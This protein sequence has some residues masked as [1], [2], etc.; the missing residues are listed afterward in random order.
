MGSIKQHGSEETGTSNPQVLNLPASILAT[1]FVCVLLI[2]D[3][4]LV[5]YACLIWPKRGEAGEASEAGDND[6]FFITGV[7]T[8]VV[9]FTL[10]FLLIF[11][12]VVSR[13]FAEMFP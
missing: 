7:V 11:G 9:C 1:V 5:L 10:P 2:F 12:F 6:P 8:F 3:G 13:I 4:S